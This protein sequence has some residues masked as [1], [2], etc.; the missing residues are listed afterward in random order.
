MDMFTENSN[1]ERPLTPLWQCVALKASN[2]KLA[3]LHNVLFFNSSSHCTTHNSLTQ[4]CYD[5]IIS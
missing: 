1:E 3:N 4:V 5:A 2:P